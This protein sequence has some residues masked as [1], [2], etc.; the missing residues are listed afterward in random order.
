MFAD[1]PSTMKFQILIVSLFATV[2][3]AGVTP[4]N[5]VRTNGTVY[6][7]APCKQV[8]ATHTPVNNVNTSS[9]CIHKYKLSRGIVYR[10]GPCAR[11][12]STSIVHEMTANK[13]IQ[14]GSNHCIHERKSGNAVEQWCASCKRNLRSESMEMKD[15]NPPLNIVHDVTANKG[16]QYWL[17]TLYS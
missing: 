9:I 14:C 1:L 15:S 4:P 11:N 10:C 7:C 16:I 13:G 8:N 12:S 17:K 5:C 6:F 3:A 2:V